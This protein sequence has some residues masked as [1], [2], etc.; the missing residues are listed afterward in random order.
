MEIQQL[1]YFVAVADA[2]SASR[3]AARCNVAQPSLSQQVMKLERTLGKRL[4]DRV[5]RGMV[6]TEAGRSFLPRARRILAEVREAEAWSGRDGTD[7]ATALAIGAIPTI[8]PYLLPGALALARK[9][10][11]ACEFTIRE[12][13]TGVMVEALIDHEID[14]AL[15]STPPDDDRLQTVTIGEEELLAVVPA[16][17][18]AVPQG[19]VALAELRDQPAVLLDE[20]HCLGQQVQAF[21]TSRK[22]GP[23]VVCRTTQ[24]STILEM[25]SLGLGF[26][27]VPEMT[28][29]ADPVHHGRRYVHLAPTRPRRPIVLVWRTGRTRSRSSMVLLE[30]LKASF[31]ARRSGPSN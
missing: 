4:F 16:T 7:H 31:Q 19:I 10:L 2:G 20:V 11:P 21:C 22:L 24:L 17:W 9:Q 8:A 27:I 30:S 3:A 14:C 25:V 12:N 13:L 5:G 26:S 15:M 1:K 29:A 18:T 28:A 6:P 23:R